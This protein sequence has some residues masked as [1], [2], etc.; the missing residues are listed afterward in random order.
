[1]AK[2]K[3]KKYDPI[4]NPCPLIYGLYTKHIETIKHYT[5]I[6]LTYRQLASTLMFAIF[7]AIGFILSEHQGWP[8]NRLILIMLMTVAGIFGILSLWYLDI[9]I[10]DRLLQTTANELIHMEKKYKWI[11]P[12]HH[13][14]IKLLYI[15]YPKSKSFLYFSFCG[16]LFLTLM[17]A[18]YLLFCQYGVPVLIASYLF[19]AFITMMAFKGI[20]NMS[21]DLYYQKDS[22]SE[23]K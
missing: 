5:R 14:H 7:F 23:E 15:E 16:I 17:I 20:T 12:V 6:Q 3:K 21:G 1:M 22:K 2:A 9:I 19:I 4:K 13:N 18:I 10:Y 8:F 11:P